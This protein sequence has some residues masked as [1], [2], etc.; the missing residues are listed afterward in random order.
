MNEI[1]TKKLDIL[2]QQIEREGQLWAS[3]DLFF[4][5]QAKQSKSLS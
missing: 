4:D 5:V 3:D 1:G 2:K